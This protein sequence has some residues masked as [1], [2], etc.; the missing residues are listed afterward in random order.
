MAMTKEGN[1]FIALFFF[2][3]EHV[4]LSCIVRSTVLWV[5]MFT[6]KGDN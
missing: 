5:H 6:I 4:L 3:L 2:N 1:E